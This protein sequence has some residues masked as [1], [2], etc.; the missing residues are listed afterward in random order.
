MKTQK[1]GLVVLAL[2]NLF[3]VS[4]ASAQ[5]GG[6]GFHGGGR[7]GYGYE[8]HGGGY[9]APPVYYQPPRYYA[10]AP[11]VVIAPPPPPPIYVDPYYNYRRGR[12]W[13]HH[14]PRVCF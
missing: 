1:I 6:R 4:A 2:L 10:P 9:C 3:C 7:G 11:R 12:G 8:H 14:R 13:H 5:H